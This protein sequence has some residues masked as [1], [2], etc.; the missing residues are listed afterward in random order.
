ML[1]CE[2]HVSCLAA[3]A[4]SSSRFH[5]ILGDNA[6]GMKASWA[7]KDMMS[8]DGSLLSEEVSRL[9]AR[10]LFDP[11]PKT[12]EGIGAM[13]KILKPKLCQAFGDKENSGLVLLR[14]D[15]G[16]LAAVA[17]VIVDKLPP[18]DVG[19]KEEVPRV[20]YLVV[21]P[22]LQGR[23]LGSL[24]M[25]HCEHWA[26]SRGHLAIWLFHYTHMTH[27]HRWYSKLGYTNVKEDILATLP[28]P[29]QGEL[30]GS[31]QMLEC[32]VTLKRKSLRMSHTAT[33]AG[34]HDLAL[35]SNASVAP[36]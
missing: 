25:R 17:G 3:L 6:V 14:G 5:R 31:M 27:L 2:Q 30:E 12:A 34:T 28:V 16:K 24:L 13:M 19:V 9:V 33:S 22:A 20:C 26:A 1:P 11:P 36:F 8:M 35:A 7:P 29:G 10:V 21:D 23:G 18:P 4:A 15:D 32:V